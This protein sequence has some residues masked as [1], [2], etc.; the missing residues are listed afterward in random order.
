MIKSQTKL[1][2]AKK[3]ISECAT[4]DGF[5]ASS[6]RYKYEYWTRD[7]A[8]SLNSLLELGYSKSAKN[9]LDQIWRRQNN[10]GEVPTL[11]ISNKGAWRKKK[12]KRAKETGRTPF[13]LEHEE[14]IE[15]R[16]DKGRRHK[17]LRKNVSPEF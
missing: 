13:M 4:D 1:K 3:V 6:D 8:H 9:H 12:L 11:A 15:G 2:E 16:R 5:Y 17:G 10:E 7:F 14:N